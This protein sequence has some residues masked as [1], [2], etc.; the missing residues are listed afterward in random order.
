MEATDWI[1]E[2]CASITVC[3]ADGRILAM[4]GAAERVFA[5]DGGAEL[6]GRNVLDCHPEPARTRLVELLRTGRVNAYTIEKQ[7][8]KKLIYQAPWYDDG[9]FAGMVELSVEIPFDLPH[10]VRG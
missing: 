6:V 4:N 3:D 5:A 8:R 9:Q 7:G 2:F 10:F 1:R